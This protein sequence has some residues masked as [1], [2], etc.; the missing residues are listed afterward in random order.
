MDCEG[1]IEGLTAR[2]SWDVNLGSL[3]SRRQDRNC[4]R[5]ARLGPGPASFYRDACRLRHGIEGIETTSHLVSHALREANGNL[6]AI[7]EAVVELK[8][9]LPKKG[10]DN[11]DKIVTK[12]LMQALGID[13]K[14]PVGRLWLRLS[15]D[16]DVPG[17]A[18][19]AHRDNLAPPRPVTD[20]RQFWDDVDTVF[21][22][23]L[24]KFEERFVVATFVV[25]DELLTRKAPGKKDVRE[26]LGKVPQNPV[27]L[28]YFCERTG[29]AWLSPLRQEGF[30]RYPQPVERDAASGG[31]SFIWWP[32]SWYLARLARENVD[33]SEEIMDVILSLPKCDNFRVWVDCADAMLDLPIEIAVR[34]V[35]RIPAWLEVT[36]S[37]QLPACLADLIKRFAREGELV[38]ALT[39]A[40]PLLTLVPVE[41][42]DE[43]WPTM[44]MPR[45]DKWQYGV[46]VR[47]CVPIVI[48]SAPFDSLTVLSDVLAE[49]VESITRL[50]KGQREP[51]P[52]HYWLDEIDALQ[53]RVEGLETPIEILVDAVRDAALTVVETGSAS[54]EEVVDNLEARDLGIFRR[55]SLTLLDRYGD[56]APHL[57]SSWLTDRSRCEDL[58]LRHEYRLLLHHRFGEL[59]KDHQVMI[60]MWIEAGPP[61]SL[62]EGMYRFPHNPERK[63]QLEKLA[64]VSDHL[65]GKWRSWYD[66]LVSEFGEPTVQL[67]RPPV[68]VRMGAES[69]L[70]PAG[71]S[72]M[73]VGDLVAYLAGFQGTNSLFGPNEDGLAATFQTIVAAEP[74]RYAVIAARFRELSPAYVS[75]LLSGLWEAGRNGR[76][77]DW[78]SVIELCGWVAKQHQPVDESPL[79]SSGWVRRTIANL[80]VFGLLEGPTQIPFDLRASVWDALCPLL[81]DPDPFEDVDIVR[82]HASE[83]IA[84]LS[85]NSTRA[86]AVRAAILYAWW[87][88]SK[89][90][91]CTPNAPVLFDG[92]DTA[93]EV[94]DVLD[95]HLS[96]AQDPSLAVRWVYGERFPLLTVLDPNWTARNIERV[97]PSAPTEAH[98]WEAAWHAYVTNNPAYV[99]VFRLLLPQ[100]GRAVENLDLGY[101]SRHDGPTDLSGHLLGLYQIGELELCAPAGLIEVFFRRATASLRRQALANIGHGLLNRTESID[102]DRQRR[103]MALWEWRLKTIRDEGLPNDRQE[104]R[105]FGWWFASGK[106]DDVWAVDQ[107]VQA[108]EVD[109]HIEVEERVVERLASLPDRLLQKALDGLVS[110]VRGTSG[111]DWLT[112]DWKGAATKIISGGLASG[113][114][115]CGSRAKTAVNLLVGRG[116]VEFLP[117]LENSRDPYG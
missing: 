72:A 68:E 89:S 41:S 76:S 12:L 33:R 63:W 39:V 59:S 26:L 58:E 30:F 106:L 45:F 105:A 9:P 49:A 15:G 60:L 19:L 78:E 14:H 25:I 4:S 83:S 40:R 113:D 10:T 55:L 87:V 7:L 38:A 29:P 8:T 61:L 21:D 90:H 18:G 67:H 64:L 88:R 62:A 116:H 44:P 92:L 1:D 82:A 42:A 84:S 36:D 71:L 27:T 32:P 100:Y 99:E 112:M 74:Q 102:Q 115:E 37:Y 70:T 52:S 6:R 111:T 3:N 31:I 110:L 103:L 11:R 48:R 2:P 81:D 13:Q 94:R 28:N 77:F 23:V 65:T 53:T 56:R 101:N 24:D 95:I 34:A 75:A 108:L 97:F 69:P 73:T 20:A 17:L 5:L 98:F 79:S 22:F 107:L 117:L 85:V 54:V 46:V 50:V 43:S 47:A 16:D 86:Q 91:P 114:E 93:P 104:V 109:G 51:R 96:P 35:P 57:V 80:L 66:D